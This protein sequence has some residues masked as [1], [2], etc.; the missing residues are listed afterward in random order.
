MN[1]VIDRFEH[2]VDDTAI[3]HIVG[4][5]SRGFLF[6]IA[7]ALR[8]SKPFVMAR[9]RGKLPPRVIS[10]SFDLEYGQDSLEIRHDSL[11]P[12][13]GVLLVDDVLATG[14]TLLGAAEL[15]ARAG[16]HV[17]GSVC[18]LEIKALRGAERLSAADILVKSILRV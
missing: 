11:S 15:V 8:M 5:E 10:V 14:G 18:F 12:G 4:I 16:A 17:V 2:L 9:K 3:T 6:G 13:A 1:A 7:L